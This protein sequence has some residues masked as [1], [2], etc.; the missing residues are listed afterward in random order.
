MRKL[1]CF[2]AATLTLLTLLAVA[3]S[4]AQ[5]QGFVALHQFDS[6]GDGA[7]PEAALVRDAA[8]NL[9]GTTIIGGGGVAGVVYKIDPTGAEMILL[10][11]DV[12]NGSGPNSPLILDQAGNLYGIANNGPLGGGVIFKLSPSGE[13]TLLHSFRKGA[14]LQPKI[15]SGGLFMDKLGNIF[16]TTRFGGDSSCQTGCGTLFKLN[17]AGVLSVVHRFVGPEGTQPFGPLVQDAAGNLYGV[18]QVGGDLACPDALVQGQGCGTVFKFSKKKVLTVLHAFQGGSDG[19]IAQAGLLLDAVGNLYGTT[20]NGG[21]SEN[22]TIFKI[23]NDGTYTVAHRFT[24]A[25][26]GTTPNG[27]LV[28]DDAGNL[29][30]TAQAGGASGM[31]TV[32]ELTPSGRLTVLH[33]FT[34]ATDGAFPLAGLIRDELGHLYGTTDRDFLPQQIQGGNVFEIRP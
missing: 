32:F 1:N 30:G 9:Y 25:V 18:T 23:S 8:G 2:F 15:P 20:G 22:G 29:F 14:N 4:P 6:A 27:G 19:A 5:A 28:I 31:G 26:D 17:Q 16:G 34:G 13:Q 21:T 11:F 33:A 10:R 3:T 24:G 12:A 7:F